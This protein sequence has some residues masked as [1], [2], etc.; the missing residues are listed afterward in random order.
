[1]FSV[2]FAFSA[3]VVNLPI[4]FVFSSRGCVQNTDCE[5]SQWSSWLPCTATCNGSGKQERKRKK[6]TALGCNGKCEGKLFEYKNCTRSCCPVNC[7]YTWGSWSSCQGSCG[8]NGTQTSL[9]NKTQNESCG[10]TCHAP[11]VRKRKCD[12]G[13]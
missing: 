3:L 8:P 11:P 2:L 4:C 12:T 10:G 5:F 9:R 7:T 6:V 13:T 1:M